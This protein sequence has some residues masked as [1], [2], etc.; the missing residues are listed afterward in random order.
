VRLSSPPGS[1]T[2]SRPIAG[3]RS[4]PRQVFSSS[5]TTARMDS[6]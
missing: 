5:P 3:S 2:R 6:P 1:Q 4:G